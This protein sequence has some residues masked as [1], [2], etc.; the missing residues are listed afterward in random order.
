[1]SSKVM[2]KNNA[3]VVVKVINAILPFACMY[4][5]YHHHHHH[6][7]KLIMHITVISIYT[8]FPY[9][10]FGF[11]VTYESMII[12]DIKRINFILRHLDV[13]KH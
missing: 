9:Y 7:P 10:I 13:I 1:M 5:W 3:Y 11:I 4:A 6:H 2:D 8:L 12:L